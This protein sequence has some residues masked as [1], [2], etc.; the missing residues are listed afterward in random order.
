[1][2]IKSFARAAMLLSFT[3]LTVML[4]GTPASLANPVAEST[5]SAASQSSSTLRQGI[6]GRRLGGGTRTESVFPSGA[7]SLVAL[8]MPDS[9]VVTTEARPP[10]MFYVPE[11]TSGNRVEFVLRNSQDELIYEKTFSVNREA[12]IVTVDLAA[13]E[14]APALSLNETYQWYFSIVP[15]EADRANDVVVYGG[16]S[17]VEVADWLAQQSV[18]SGMREQLAVAAPLQKARLLYQQANLWQ[19]AAA[20][21]N[22]LRQA[23]PENA[24]IAAEWNQLL[25]SVG[26]EIAAGAT[27]APAKVAL[28]P[29][30]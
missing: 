1:M 25:A 30:Y 22:E 26:L 19:D 27:S 5:I 21:L 15:N 13:D 11:M 12:G 8:A 20:I 18:E 10:L 3:S 24:A 14:N 23:E 4:A 16:I 7:R 2:S 9:F 6:P 29:D 17:R 28:T